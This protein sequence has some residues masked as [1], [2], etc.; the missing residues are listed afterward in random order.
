MLEH[1]HGRRASQ[2]LAAFKLRFFEDIT[3]Q[4]LLAIVYRYHGSTRKYWLMI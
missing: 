3:E 1:K 2:E 4:K